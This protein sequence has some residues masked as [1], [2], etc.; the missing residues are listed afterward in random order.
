M[1]SDIS[2]RC[3]LSEGNLDDRWEALV[4]APLLFETKYR[5]LLAVGGCPIRLDEQNGSLG[6]PRT[7]LGE[8]SSPVPRVL[9]VSRVG[10]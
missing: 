4:P 10:H 2:A 9:P 8:L 5:D 7:S 6:R 1:S 3:S